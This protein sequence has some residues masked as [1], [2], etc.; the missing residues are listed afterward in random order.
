M[1]RMFHYIHERLDSAHSAAGTGAAGPSECR[2][3]QPLLP[4]PHKRTLP[5]FLN[6]L[7]VGRACRLL[8]EGGANVTEVAWR[9]RVFN[10]SRTSTGSS[11]A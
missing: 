8:A 3:V 11:A 5:Q 9:V 10:N 1:T 2:G 4:R 6:E 7:R